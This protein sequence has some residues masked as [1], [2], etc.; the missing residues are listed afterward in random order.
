MGWTHSRCRL[1]RGP[2]SSLSHRGKANY[3]CLKDEAP[4]AAEE[5]SLLG[6]TTMRV[7]RL[8]MRLHS[9]PLRQNQSL[10]AGK[11]PVSCLNL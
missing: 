5:G 8:G 2:A 11:S 9:R 6:W 3:L 4:A 10:V 7:D 1:Q